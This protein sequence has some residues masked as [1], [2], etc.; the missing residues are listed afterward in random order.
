MPLMPKIR[1][2]QL[3]PKMQKMQLVRKMQRQKR[4]KRYKLRKRHKKYK[5]QQQKLEL[6]WVQLIQISFKTSNNTPNNPQNL[7]P[8]SKSVDPRSKLF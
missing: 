4:L 6:K 8:Y 7:E 1:K 5:T 3:M 2:M